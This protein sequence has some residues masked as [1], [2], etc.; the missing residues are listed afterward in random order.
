[1]EKK[2]TVFL[3]TVLRM[4]QIPGSPYKHRQACSEALCWVVVLSYLWSTV[5][6][7]APDWVELVI[8]VGS[9]LEGN[10]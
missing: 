4:G 2:A 3:I 8:W 6:G 1:M 9:V 7:W 5:I 10:Q